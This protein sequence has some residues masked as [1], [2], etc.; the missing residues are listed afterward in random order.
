[1]TFVP[2]YG[3]FDGK[4]IQIKVNEDTEFFKWPDF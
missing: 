4:D 3:K 2:K 1:M